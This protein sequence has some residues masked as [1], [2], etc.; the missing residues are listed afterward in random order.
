[1]NFIGGYWIFRSV[2]CGVVH[3]KRNESFGCLRKCLNF[4]K[5]DLR[6]NEFACGIAKGMRTTNENNF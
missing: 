3:K 6:F 4:V 1:M 5:I 2:F